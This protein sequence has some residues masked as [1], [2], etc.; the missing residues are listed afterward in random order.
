MSSG[1]IFVLNGERML[2][3]T[4][5]RRRLLDVLRDD[6]RLT[7]TKEG[8]GT[9]HCGTC[10]VLVDGEVT[11]SCLTPLAKVSGKRVTTIEGIGSPSS[12]HPLQQAFVRRGAIQCGFCSPGMII[13]AKALLDANPR[14]S[15]QDVA[16]GLS[17]NLCRCTGYTKV[18][19]AVLEAAGI[20]RGDDRPRLVEEPRAVGG[21]VPHLDALAKGTGLATYAAD[22]AME[23]M[24]HAAV[25][26]SPYP[27]AIIRS[28]DTA[29]ALNSDG[30]RAVLTAQDIPGV[31][32]V[33]RMYRDQ[34]VLAEGK[35]RHVG[36]P[37]AVVAATSRL[38]AR[39]ALGKIKVM[40]SPMEPIFDPT[41]TLA[42]EAPRIHEGGNLLVSYR[43]AQGD[44]AKGFDQADVILED[45]FSTTFV[46]HAYLEPE[47]GLAYVDEGGI[48]TICSPIQNPHF[49]Q[50]EIARI[51]GVESEKVRIIHTTCGGAFGGKLDLSVQGVLALLAHR[52]Q[53]PVR[54]VYSRRESFASSA[55]RHP[56][57][58]RYRL[59]ATRDG[60]LNA[61]QV[62]L[63][64]DTGA[65]AS[66]GPAVLLN[67]TIH[68]S[69]PYEIPHLLV[70]GK[71]V[72]TNNPYCGAMRAF[73][74]PQVSFAI[75]S[76]MDMLAQR[77][78]I[79]PL[80][81]RLQNGL[82]PGARTATGQV[83]ADG[84]RLGATLEAVGSHWQE[85]RARRDRLAGRRRVSNVRRGVGVASGWYG[86]GIRFLANPAEARAEL[87]ADG[88]LNV[89]SG[90][91]DV[92]QGS[93]TVL[94]QI[95]AEELGVPLGSVNLVSADTA[96]TPDSWATVHSRQTFM[97][98]NAVRAACTALKQSLLAMACRAL[99]AP[100][101]ELELADS[102]VFSRRDPQVRASIIELAALCRE[103]G[104]PLS[105]QGR[106]DLGVAALDPKDGQGTPFQTYAFATQMAEVAVNVLTGEVKV[107]RLVAAHDVGKAINPLAVE[108]QIQGGVTMGLGF[109]L[110]EAF[111]PGET[112][113][114][115]DYKIPTTMDMPQ[116]LP[117]VVESPDPAGPFG[118]IGVGEIPLCPVAPAIANAI[119][120][121][122]GVR[123]SDLPLTPDRLRLVLDAARGGS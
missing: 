77:I 74:V 21:R 42:E 118:A 100:L 23:G 93:S 32:R 54:L 83:L 87:G 84:P 105:H 90:A 117:I 29:A 104:V 37:V 123:L 69:G 36:E 53:K 66:A 22:L 39:R 62:E 6:L 46:E 51:L 5:P 82:G 17:G 114:F 41:R 89:F 34:P 71:S 65:Y 75:E 111:I 102:Q 55:K 61:L 85:Y 79:D 103:A 60:R 4:D 24:F 26:R 70:E 67:A 43:I 95:A 80:E 11:K 10:Y 121:A 86:I 47:A 112:H 20:L 14:P 115:K 33:G 119:F 110:K 97:S 1:I 12:P 38:G 98:G 101:D 96:T 18:I 94:A 35:V 109:A 120:D 44:V 16:R 45:S 107:E 25:L 28:I 59:G 13:A 49:A 78:G 27:H 113:G 76:M 30:V 58:M 122:C 72:Y 8:C 7:G 50:A 52:L 92:G 15:P 116:I 81:L 2:L 48:L 40:Y 9:G 3:H 19:E 56:F 63:V 99:E 108:G 106:C 57:R 91:A 88:K 64:A 31:N 68:A 73:G